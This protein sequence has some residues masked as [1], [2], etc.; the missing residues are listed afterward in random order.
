MRSKTIIRPTVGEIMNDL[1]LTN[2]DKL[3][4]G[5]LVQNYSDYIVNLCSRSVRVNSNR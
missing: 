3:R 1:E 5:K 2:N 4:I